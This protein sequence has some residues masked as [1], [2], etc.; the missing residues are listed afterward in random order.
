[1]PGRVY[2]TR[3]ASVVELGASTLPVFDVPA[4]DVWVVR[5]VVLSSLHTAPQRIDC[6]IYAPSLE[7]LGP[8][9]REVSVRSPGSR[10]LLSIPAAE[11]NT[12]YH[13]EVEQVIEFPETLYVAGELG[14]YTCLVTGWHLLV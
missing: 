11:P 12:S 1:M 7:E 6:F 5:D 10:M 8:E 2:T 4:T 14:G 9:Q 13:E 3:L